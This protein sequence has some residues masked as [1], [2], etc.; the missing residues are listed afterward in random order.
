MREYDLIADWYAENRGEATGVAEVRALCGMLPPRA[1]VL[2]IGC[3][4]GKPLT[5]EL[6]AHG[7]RVTALDSSSRMLEY[8]RRNFPDVVRLH[9]RIE[10]DVLPEST[11]DAVLAWG[12]LFHLDHVAQESALANIGRAL[13]PGGH[14]L[15]TSGREHGSIQGSPMGGVEFRYWSFSE[16]G[17]RQRLAAHGV[18]LERSQVDAG[19][20]THYWARKALY[21][22]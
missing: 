5:T 17:Y 6:V 18:T 14:L 20:N 7:C 3:G 4:T 10:H 15:F 9:G 1:E 16:D 11:Y 13:K 8:F 2:D 22:P 12:V 21:V 19:D